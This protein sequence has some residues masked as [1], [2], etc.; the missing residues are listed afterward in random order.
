MTDASTI[1][2]RV[3]SIARMIRGEFSISEN[4]HGRVTAWITLA[5]K[6]DLIATCHALKAFDARL[7]MI[8]ALADR[9]AGFN[10]LAYHFDIEGSTVTVKVKLVSGA[11]IDSIVPIFRNADW[12]EREFMEFYDIKCTGRTDNRRLFLDESVDGRV[13]ERLIP[14]SVISN[15]ASTN[16]L[17]ERLITDREKQ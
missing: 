12:H 15:A 5:D 8:T 4:R 10:L 3:M 7:S 11:S 17:F 16:M 14:L 1:K 9:N 2:D 13:M 6:D